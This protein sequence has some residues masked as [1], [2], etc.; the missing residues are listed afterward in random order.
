MA[1]LFLIGLTLLSLSLSGNHGFGSNGHATASLIILAVAVFKARLVGLYFMELK[2]APL[3]LRA[4]FEAYCV[5]LVALLSGM[6][7]MG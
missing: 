4:T 5:V 6:Y 3:L 7:L 2:A 1:W